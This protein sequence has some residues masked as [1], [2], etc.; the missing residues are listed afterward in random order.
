MEGIE[1]KGIELLNEEQK[2]E[3]NKEIEKYKEKLKWKTKSDFVLKFVIKEYSHKADDKDNKRKKYSIQAQIKGET[4]TFDA[5]ADDWDFN[6]L[7][8]KI[9]TKLINEVEHFYHSSEQKNT[10]VRFRKE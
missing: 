1:I 4:R 3:F 8:H 2:W 9:F 6:K 10:S 5:S 7:V